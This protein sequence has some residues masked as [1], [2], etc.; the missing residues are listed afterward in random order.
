[1]TTRVH[2]KMIVLLATLGLAAIALAEIPEPPD[3]VES[4]IVAA[5]ARSQWV[6]KVTEA[7]S[8]MG[9]GKPAEALAAFEALQREMPALD[10]DGVVALAIGDCQFRLKQY[11]KAFGTY[12]AG[13]QLHPG[14]AESIW[15]RLVETELSMGQFDQA[16]ARLKQVLAGGAPPQQKVWASLRLGNLQEQQAIELLGRAGQ[17]YRQAADLDA[18]EQAQ[19]RGRSWMRTHADDLKDAA[20]QIQAALAQMS[21]ELIPVSWTGLGPAEPLPE[22]DVDKVRIDGRIDKAT[23][24]RRTR[25]MLG[26]D[27]IDSDP[28]ELSIDKDGKVEAK[29]GG[30]K[31]VLD[32]QTQR[33]ILK[34]LQYTLR[35]AGQAA[36]EPAAGRTE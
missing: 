17:T 31:V 19:V 2:N 32:G 34:H 9:E 4:D 36:R 20:A 11:E 12:Q 35:V 25:A 24:D 26:K 15:A 22:A 27:K 1:M 7:S 6:R 33:Q 3:P 23:I 18:P 8:L 13:A 14:L 5:Q 29:L 16:A 10:T 21:V 28:V 30:K